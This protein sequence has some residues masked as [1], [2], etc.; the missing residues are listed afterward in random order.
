M[1]KKF[2][3]KIEYIIE[4]SMNNLIEIMIMFDYINSKKNKEN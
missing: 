4:I 3:I 2:Q 1:L